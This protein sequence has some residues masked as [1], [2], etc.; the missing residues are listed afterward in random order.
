MTTLTGVISY[1]IPAYSNV[2]IEPQFYQPKIFDISAMSYGTYTTVTTSVDH[3]YVIGQLIR[4]VIPAQDGC[5][6]LNGQTGYV[7]S[8]PSDSQVVVG[9]NSK[10]SDA[11]ANNNTRQSAQIA[12]IGD[13]NSG[14]VN[15]GHTNNLTYIPGSFI[16]ISPA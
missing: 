14:Q 12:A 7:L 15:T 10:G 4:L 3:D 9:I 2:P 8:V 16:N 1:P 11:F 6:N 13:V 5:Y